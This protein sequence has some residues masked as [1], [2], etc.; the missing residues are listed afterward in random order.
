MTYPV[1]PVDKTVTAQEIFD[2]VALH[3]IAQNR[4]ST[5]PA[6]VS[7][8]YRNQANLACAVGCLMTDE[9]A[10]I[11]DSNHKGSSIDRLKLDGK[12]PERFLDHLNLLHRLQKVH[13]GHVE[14]LVPQW[15]PALI[16]VAEEFGLIATRFI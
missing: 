14:T 13:D 12:I 10:S 1:L 5:S 9:E 8:M 2:A 11:A 4:L 16:A 3:L 15:K 7:C 6:G